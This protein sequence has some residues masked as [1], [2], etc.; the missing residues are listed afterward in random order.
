MTRVNVIHIHI[1]VYLWLNF[2][3]LKFRDTVYREIQILYYVQYCIII[4]HGKMR[5]AL[6]Y[7][8]GKNTDKY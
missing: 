7:K 8:V 5:C 2:Y 1:S 3:N 6:R 4:R